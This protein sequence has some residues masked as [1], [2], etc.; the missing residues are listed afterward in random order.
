MTSLKY[1][2]NA[3]CYR[4]QGITIEIGALLLVENYIN[5]KKTL[6]N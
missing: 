5:R 2:I 1:Q 4:D 3:I 6:K